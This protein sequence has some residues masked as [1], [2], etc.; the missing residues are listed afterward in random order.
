MLLML[1]FLM[2]VTGMVEIQKRKGAYSILHF[3]TA[4]GVFIYLFYTYVI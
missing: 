2:F 4:T 1:G 3:L